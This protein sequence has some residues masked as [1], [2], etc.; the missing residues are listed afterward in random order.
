M[1]PLKRRSASQNHSSKNTLASLFLP[2]HWDHSR[3]CVL[4]H[5]YTA[6]WVHHTGEAAEYPNRGRCLTL[7][8]LNL[9]QTMPTIS[10]LPSFFKDIKIN[11][12]LHP[13]CLTSWPV[14][15]VPNIFQNPK[16]I[17]CLL[18]ECASTQNLWGTYIEQPTHICQPL[19]T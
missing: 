3:S 10:P 18:P 2:S 14:Y 7:L 12:A 19:C 1:H 6:D 4:I 9:Y 5:P 11:H 17:V 13:T 16:S 15:H 8:S